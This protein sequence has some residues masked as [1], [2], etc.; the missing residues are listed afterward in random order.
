MAVTKAQYSAQSAELITKLLSTTITQPEFKTQWADLNN[1]YGVSNPDLADRQGKFIEESND[2]KKG[3]YDWATGTVNG[4]PNHDGMYPIKLVT[5]GTVMWPCIAR[6]IDPLYGSESLAKEYAER[7]EAALASFLENTDNSAASAALAKASELAAKASETAAA[8]S[9]TQAEA[10]KVAAALS[11]TNAHNSELAAK[12]SELAAQA[13]K[14]AAEA[15][16]D[17]AALSATDAD[18]AKSAAVTAKTAAEAAK[19][20]A[21]AARDAAGLVQADVTTSRNIAQAA[22]ATA[23]S[24]KTDAETARA[25]AVTKAAEAQAS[26]DAAA[27]SAT[28]AAASATQA[29][30]S[31]TTAQFYGEQAQQNAAGANVEAT[32]AMNARDLANTYKNQAIAAKT[33][34][35]TAAANAATSEANAYDS[36]Q[37]AGWAKRDAVNAVIVAQQAV[38]QVQGLITEAEDARDAAIEAANDAEDAQALSETARDDAVVAKLAAEAAALQAAQTVGFD[39]TDYQLKSAKGQPNGYAGLD[40]NGKVPLSQ[41]DTAVL[42]GLNYQGTWNAATNTPAI[43]AASI[44]NKG[45]YFIVATSGTTNVDGITDWQVSDLIMSNG[46][47]W[48]KLD[49]TN[50]VLKVNNKTGDITL[51]KADVALGNVDNTSDANKPI[52]TATQA[53]LDLKLNIAS[54]ANNTDATTGTDDA[55]YMTAAKTKAAINGA[56]ITQSQV[57]NLTETLVLKL[58]ATEKGVANGLASLD[59]NGKVPAAQL[60][61]NWS[62]ISGKP[63]TFT[64]SAHNHVL[65]DITDFQAFGDQIF[66]KFS[67]Y[68]SKNQKGQPDGYAGLNGVGKIDAGFLDVQWDFMTGKPSTFPPSVHGHAFT[69]ITGLNTALNNKLDLTDAV[70]SLNGR[71]GFVVITAA[72]VALGNVDNTSDANK[73]IST[74][75]QTALDA[76]LAIS[77]KATAGEATAGTDDTKYMT[78]AKTAQA[79]GVAAITQA[80][81]TGLSSALAGKVADGDALKS[82][83]QVIVTPA[84]TGGVLTLDLSLGSVFNVSWNANITSINVT[85]CPSG[86]VSWTLVLVGAGG[87]SV[88]WNTTTFKFPGGTAPTLL[89]NAGAHNFMSMA[90]LNAGSR[91]NVFF[92]G[93]TV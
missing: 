16:R 34:A 83:R 64:P 15:A 63:S 89:S 87:S 31:A 46:Q 22:A 74:A 71:K 9:K 75:T 90:T 92:S 23:V 3:I 28:S 56:T 47:F 18:G 76:K 49:Q 61:L 26:A 69:D 73:P 36:Q 57:T 77:S 68:Q 53:A 38:T 78:P 82:D 24:A 7:A 8:T 59:S 30:A 4:G 50:Q 42:G 65:A 32:A 12:A 27:G 88:S 54:K 93:A 1:A 41:L 39:I 21:E 84:I 72:D 60:D 86:M 80:Q 51:T 81:V 20:A 45:Q 48:H 67:T 44:A 91:V 10:A 55:K 85:N 58:D 13:A 43:P 79:I 35:E 33:A 70:R 6:I 66:G 62:G 40:A 52:S 19:I 29:A 17:A 37:Q 2:L 5:G 25:T 11:E 14:L